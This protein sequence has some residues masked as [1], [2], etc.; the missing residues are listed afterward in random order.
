[1]TRKVSS[2]VRSMD[3]THARTHVRGDNKAERR[4]CSEV[5]SRVAST[6]NASL[7]ILPVA[8]KLDFLHGDIACRLNCLE[9]YLDWG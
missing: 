3:H 4:E 2:Q 1:M 8:C 5:N 9:M 7:Q 6:A